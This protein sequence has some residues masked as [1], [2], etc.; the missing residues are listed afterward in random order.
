MKKKLN[1]FSGVNSQSL[2]RLLAAVGM[3]V[4]I[5]ILSFTQVFAQQGKT[6][7]G[8]VVDNT[9]MS[10]PGV[11]VSL[12]GTTSGTITSA[13]GTYT[14]NVP[15]KGK[16]LVFSFVGMKTSE[17]EIGS[18]TTINVI[19]TEESIGLEEVVAVGYGTQ[20]KVSLTGSVGTAV[21]WQLYK[22][23]LQVLLLPVVQGNLDVKAGI[24]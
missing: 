5:I 19:M 6:I 2:K 16:I 17:V 1:E 8:K 3:M 12:K 22:D 20:K 23:R 10:L 14:L 18:Q 24:S 11:S 13:E 21:H 4:L 7:K 9:N 15:E